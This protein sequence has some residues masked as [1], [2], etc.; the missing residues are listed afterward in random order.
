MRVKPML[1][2][3]LIALEYCRRMSLWLSLPLLEKYLTQFCI[4]LRQN[5][6]FVHHPSLLLTSSSM[7]RFSKLG[8]EPPNREASRSLAIL[9]RVMKTCY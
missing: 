3:E 5:K 9:E 4:G 7:G 8:D 6:I 1:Q 2:M